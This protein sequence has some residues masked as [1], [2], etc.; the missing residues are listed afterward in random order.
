A[1]E[2]LALLEQ[3]E[4]RTLQ[5]AA[6]ES[7]EQTLLSEVELSPSTAMKTAKLLRRRSREAPKNS[8]NSEP[9]SDRQSTA[10]TSAASR[11]ASKR[12]SVDVS[13]SS[14]FGSA[15]VSAW[16][17]SVGNTVGKKWEEIQK[18]DTRLV[19]SSFFAALA[20]PS[21]SSQTSRPS[22]SS[23]LSNTMST[24]PN[25]ATMPFSSTKPSPVPSNGSLLDDDEL[26]GQDARSQSQ[27]LGSANGTK[28]APIPV[29]T[30]SVD[31]DDDWNWQAQRERAPLLVLS[32]TGAKARRF[33]DFHPPRFFMTLHTTEHTAKAEPRSADIEKAVEKTIDETKVTDVEDASRNTVRWDPEYEV[34]LDADEDPKML[35]TW[36]KWMIV[37]LICTCAL[38]CT[39][40]SSV[41]AFTE[42]GLSEQFHVSKEVSILSISLFVL[43]LGIGPLLNGPMSEVYGRNNVYRVSLFLFWAFTWPVTFPPDIGTFLAFRFI[44]GFCGAAFLSVAGGSVSDLFEG[45]KVPS[46]MACYTISPFIGPAVGPLFAGFINQNANWKWTFRVMLIWI[47]VEWSLLCLIIPE[48]YSP[49]LRKRKAAKL[50][51]TTGDQ[52]YWAPLDQRHT[53]MLYSILMSCYVPFK[54]LALDRMA[55]LLD[56]WSAIVLGI[57]YLAFQAFPIIFGEQHGFNTQEIGLSFAGIGIGMIIA[58]CTQPLWNSLYDRQAKQHGGVRPPECSLVMGQVGAVIL[59]MSLFW[60]AFTSYSSVHWIVPIIASV[61]FGSGVLFCFISTFT[62]LVTAYRPIAASAMAANSF[63][64][65]ASAAAFPLFAAQMYHRMGTPGATA[66]LAG[67][68]TLS[69]PLPF[70]FYRIGARLRENSAM[71]TS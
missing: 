51:K 70:I 9:A 49:V 50:R 71:A 59:P 3:D 20:S 22:A 67:L 61:P 60:L 66:F 28:T 13:A 42:D 69:A 48:T 21:P 5:P 4:D 54:H 64:R 2:D 52:R 27:H 58:L 18:G 36:R 17:G 16:M 23:P 65:S 1:D 19:S 55:L 38:C 44:T 45:H 8:L 14:T 41:S 29:P 10:S 33:A 31:D 25:L 68:T 37:I 35:P 62:Y 34:T 57:L 53:S 12:I 15:P 32:R 30:A 43:G 6:H 40:A 24:S 56:F 26:G 63:V 11:K 46:P 47:F 39:C 7:S